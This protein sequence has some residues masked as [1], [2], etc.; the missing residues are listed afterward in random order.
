MNNQA[1]TALTVQAQ[2][3]QKENITEAILEKI[4][5][6]FAG[7]KIASI[8]DKAGYETVREA[9]I[10]C[11]KI[12]VAAKKICEKGREEAR[13][14]VDAWLAEQNRVVRRIEAVEKPLKETE[15]WYDN[16]VARLKRE[17]A[18]AET[19]MI[20]GRIAAMAGY[21]VVMSYEEAQ[22]CTD[23][24][25]QSRIENEKVLYEKRCEAERIESER[26]ERERIEKEAREAEERRLFEEQQAEL[27]RQQ[28]ELAA[29][30]RAV[31]ERAAANRREEERIAQE[32]RHAQ[33]LQEQR[34]REERARIE[35]EHRNAERIE[36]EKAEAVAAER[37]RVAELERQ[38]K[39]DEEQ[40]QREVEDAK[41][42]EALRKAQ[43]PDKEKLLEFAGTVTS[44]ILPEMTTVAG[45]TIT[46][47]V[48]T[49]F[50][51]IQNYI[52]KEIEKL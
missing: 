32:R 16:E 38:R 7:L 10:T 42:L 2:A 33:E 15:E 45:R 44:I 41:R 28:E 17:K 43:A 5:K 13:R 37:Q 50:T 36:R 9:R 52:I 11:K 22:N 6:D 24:E 31:E 3:L 35:Q 40:R 48:R 46:D 19:R 12:R 29:Q 21:G 27:K 51:K 39:A 23:E 8:D 30:Q 4:E 26:L 20:A 14:E 49:L 25:Y 47:N 18:E 34:Q 1:T